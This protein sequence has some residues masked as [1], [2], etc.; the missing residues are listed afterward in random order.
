[1]TEVPVSRAPQA[2]PFWRDVHKI[3]ILLQ[4][5][6][7]I[8]VVVVALFLANNVQSGLERSNLQVSTSFW[9]QPAGIAIG[10]GPAYAPTDSYG[11]AFLIGIANTLRVAVLGVIMATL[12][13]LFVGVA[14]LS[15]NWL[16]RNLTYGY[17][18]VIRNTPLL[19]QLIF[20]FTLTSTFPVA[21]NALTIGNLLAF[22]N[23]GVYLATPRGTESFG[24]WQ[25]W[26]AGA[27]VVAI[28]VFI[29]RRQTLIREDR[30]GA[31]I[32]FSALAFVLIAGIGFLVTAVGAGSA[33]LYLDSPVLERFNFEGG[34][35]FTSA[36]AA[37][38]WGLVVYT[39][40]FIGEIVRAGIQ[41]VSK[42]QREAA[43]SLGLSNTMMLRLIILPQAMRVIIPPLTNQYLNLTKNS[44]LA[45][46][47]AYPDLFF[48]GAT[49]INQTGQTILVFTMIMA[50]YLTFSL[51]TSLAMN[52][53]NRRIQIVER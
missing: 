38:L 20:W 25:L 27:L 28:G 3:A 19:L 31:I 35:V 17:I 12:L 43:L 33:P 41:A 29:W 44:S 2:V 22:T 53:Y 8:A 45:I 14:R 1:M 30:P 5:L 4:I 51:S 36:F 9:N 39:G 49:T 16:L 32:P 46:A 6:F 34:T 13:G 47:I 21:L 23:R 40:A 11:R 42:G 24:S 7:V 52:W 37:L 26:L 50:I 18:E 10:E 48:I 15:D